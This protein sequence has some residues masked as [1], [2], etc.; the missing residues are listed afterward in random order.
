MGRR[1]EM[2]EP[3]ERKPELIDAVAPVLGF[4]FVAAAFLLF[5]KNCIGG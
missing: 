1:A 4:L 2:L 5:F 3:K